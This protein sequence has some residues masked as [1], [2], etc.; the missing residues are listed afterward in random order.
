MVGERLEVGG[1]FARF[2]VFLHDWGA[3]GRGE[4]HLLA[5][6]LLVEVARV[7]LGGHLWLE[8]WLQLEGKR[9]SREAQCSS[10]RNAKHVSRRN[11]IFPTSKLKIYFFCIS[12]W[13]N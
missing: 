6:E 2:H 3:V 11:A 5:R 13:Q 7:R 9:E 10:H 12:K 4:M 1:I 8:R